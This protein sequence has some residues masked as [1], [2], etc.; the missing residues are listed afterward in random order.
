MPRRRLT[1]EQKAAQTAVT[2]ALET[3]HT[4]RQA[5]GKYWSCIRYAARTIDNLRATI[6]D[7]ERTTAE[8]RHDD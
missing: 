4:N 2:A 5:K 7:A 6:D 3:A 1:P 8:H